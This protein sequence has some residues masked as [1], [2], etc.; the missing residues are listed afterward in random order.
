MIYIEGYALLCSLGETV[1]ESVL[2]LKNEKHEA[3]KI[4]DENLYYFLKNNPLPNYYDS[5]ESVA[6]QAI[7]HAKLTVTEQ[8]KMGIFLGT[9]S[10]KL[11]INEQ[12]LRKGEEILSSVDISEIVDE[13]AQRVGQDN[14]KGIIS[15][16]CTSSA[17]ALVQAKAMLEAGL[18]E[19]ALVLGVELYNEM[20]IKGF[21][22]FMLLSKD[23]IRPFDKNRDGVI[24][25]E[26]L[27]AVVLGKKESAFE[28][29]AGSVMVD[30]S[31]ITSPTTENL[32]RVMRHV[33]TEAKIDAEEIY[34]VKSHTTA[35]PQNDEVEAEALKNCFSKLPI[36]TALK[37]YIGHTMGAS[38]TNELVLMLASL[39]EGFVPK[40]LN[41]QTPDLNALE[42]L[43]Q[44]CEAKASYYL[45]NYFG[46]GGNNC[47]LLVKYHG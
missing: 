32:E 31:S 27:S 3:S 42:P 14:Y 24:L 8:R 9:S 20:S 36:V 46:F 7:E 21:D 45:F 15:T 19:K 37:P 34:V 23:K 29:V 6:K 5:I 26:G 44:V 28:L 18:I 22:S 38:G 33:F 11:P 4:D 30:I 35:T 12:R 41:F 2:A 10:P 43:Q 1:E 40:T 39:K 17:N 16:A 47:S 25:G 13:L